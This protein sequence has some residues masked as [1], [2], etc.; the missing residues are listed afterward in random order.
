MTKNSLPI[1]NIVTKTVTLFVTNN[2]INVEKSKNLSAIGS[3]IL[4]RIVTFP[5]F[6]AKYPSKKSVALNPTKKIDSIL[7]THNDEVGKKAIN[8]NG[9][10]NCAPTKRT[11]VKNNGKYVTTNHSLVATRGFEPRTFG[12]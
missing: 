6:L 11:N 4:P 8:T 3:R 10:K 2:A 9:K 1:S 12:L 5:Y 7:R